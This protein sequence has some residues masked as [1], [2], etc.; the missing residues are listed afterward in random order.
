[1]TLQIFSTLTII[2]VIFIFI[3]LLTIL[4]T[5]KKLKWRRAATYITEYQ[6]PTHVIKKWKTEYPNMTNNQQ[7]LALKALK[8]F[9]MIYAKSNHINK[10]SF[11]FDMPSKIADNLWHQF[12]LSSRDYH[13]FCDTAFGRYLHHKQH[14]EPKLTD[15]R[16]ENLSNELINTFIATKSLE[17][18][19]LVGSLPLIFALDSIINIPGVFQ[20]DEANIEKQLKQ[21]K[22]SNSSSTNCG[23][24]APINGCSS[25]DSSSSC[26][27]GSSCG[28]D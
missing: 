1:M 14:D 18:Q 21:A 3:S 27:S 25:N 22:T 4:Q 12:I 16:K 10:K 7:E 26:D 19:K 11:A 20:Y 5:N 28:G 2:T 17:P 23:S 8:Q 9:F 6:F 15:L 24:P 13:I